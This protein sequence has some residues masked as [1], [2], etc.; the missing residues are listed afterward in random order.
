MEPNPTDKNVEEGTERL[1][2]LEGACVVPIGGGSSM[3]RK[4]I[5][6]LAANGGSV[7]SLQSSEPKNAE[8][9]VIAV[10]TTAERGLRRTV[11]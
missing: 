8:A 5:A 7:E 3:D 11:A 4:S 1:K 2:Q 9:P 10:P 6:L